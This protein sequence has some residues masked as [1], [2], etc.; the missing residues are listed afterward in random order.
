MRYDMM[1]MGRSEVL[2]GLNVSVSE[3]S[4][5]S[6]NL[7]SLANHMIE[8]KTINNDTNKARGNYS[9]VGMVE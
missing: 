5:I 7:H 6:Y 9:R 1:L 2:C 8:S 3:N 4:K